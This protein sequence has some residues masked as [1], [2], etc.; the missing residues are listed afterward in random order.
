MESAPLFE[1]G[2]YECQ[3]TMKCCHSSPPTYLSSMNYQSPRQS[4]LAC[5]MTVLSPLQRETHLANSRDLFL[6]LKEIR[7]LSNGYEFG[8]HGPNVVVQAAEFISLEKLCC[9]FLKFEIEVEAE[10]GPVWLKLTGREGVKEFI[11][12][13]ISGLLRVVQIAESC[14][15]VHFEVREFTSPDVVHNAP[16]A[17]T[18]T[19]VD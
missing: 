12:E 4:P 19:D 8:I 6:T 17:T 1:R 7:E 9:P 11:R 18:V 15:P 2:L 16:R 5:D 13:E 10:N 3:A 14:N